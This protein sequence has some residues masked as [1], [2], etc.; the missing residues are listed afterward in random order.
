MDQ[1][2]LSGFNRALEQMRSDFNQGLNRVAGGLRSYNDKQLSQLHG[3]MEELSRVT[4]AMHGKRSGG[5]VWTG[6]TTMIEDIPGRRVPYVMVVDIPISSSDTS[7]RESSIT[8][9]Q[10]GPFVAVRRMATFQSVFEYQVTTPSSTIARFTGRSY[11]RYRPVHSVCDIMDSQH[12]STGNSSQWWLAAIANP[13]S[14]V[15]TQLP[16]GSL[17]LASNMSSFRSMQFD[18]RISV[19]NAGSSYPR[20]N[21]SVPSAFWAAESNTP[22]ALGALD[23]FERGEVITI[24]VQPNHV[25][26]APAGNVDGDAV[27]PVRTAPA[28]GSGGYPFVEGQYDAHEGIAAPGSNTLGLLSPLA[29][30]LV[31]TDKVTRLPDGILTVAYEGYRIIQPSGVPG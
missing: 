11:G 8:I 23:F 24:R 30:A 21:I 7:I 19:I 15:G 12:N 31:S 14:I 18:G 25:N 4:S 10:E 27:F 1:H 3:R 17:G 2:D 5:R 26:N 22:V 29:P 20:Q 6:R 16:T 13:A 9:S 28:F